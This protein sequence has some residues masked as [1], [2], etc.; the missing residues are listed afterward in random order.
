MQQVAVKTR[1]APLEKQT[2]PRL[3]LLAA[4][5]LARLLKMVM[6]SVSDLLPITN[7]RCW[8]DSLVSFYWITGTQHEWKEF[9][10]R[11]VV[12]IRQS[13]P[14][15][16]W[17]YCPT[18]SNPADLP[19]RGILPSNLTDS[20]WFT[21]PEWLRQ[22]QDE[23]THSVSSSVDEAAVS[24]ELKKTPSK[25]TALLAT[26][27]VGSVIDISRFSSLPKLVKTTAYVMK[28]S[29]ALK[30]QRTDTLSADS[31]AQAQTMWE[32]DVQLSLKSSSKFSDWEKEFGLFAD[33]K[34]IWR[35][36]GRLQHADL[37]YG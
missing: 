25:A 10:E 32:K 35:C 15:S 13:V 33:R 37:S 31:I 5:I 7:I 2:I 8:T 30:G 26:A 12:E 18:E 22:S 1:V 36:G 21:G 34:G 29:D 14:A 23:P 4:L 9:V 3:E 19:T 17:A 27:G 11:R 24:A 28:F 6:A 20:I 16:A